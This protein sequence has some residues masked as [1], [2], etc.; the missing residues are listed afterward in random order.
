MKF[1][2]K[3][4]GV[5]CPVCA[6]K[7]ATMIAELDGISNVKINLFTERLTIETELSEDD[8]LPAVIKTAKA[9]SRGVDI[10]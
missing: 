6:S 1:K 9:F 2:Y 5:D 10:T 8:F 7:L 4:T 3:I